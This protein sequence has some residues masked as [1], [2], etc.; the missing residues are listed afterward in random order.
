MWFYYYLCEANGQVVEVRH[1]LVQRIE[2]WGELCLAANLV[3]GDTD[4]HAKVERL[5]SGAM[6]LVQR[7]QNIDKEAPSK[8]LEL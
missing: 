1:A 4:P 3:C 5:I 7:F 6:P 8:K 2:T